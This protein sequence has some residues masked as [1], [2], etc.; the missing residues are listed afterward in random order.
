MEKIHCLPKSYI[1][2][3]AHRLFT[4]YWVL[5]NCEWP[6][7][8]GL[9]CSQD[10]DHVHPD[11]STTL[12]LRVRKNMPFA[13]K[14]ISYPRRRPKRLLGLQINA[15][16]TWG[17]GQVSKCWKKEEKEKENCK[18]KM[19]VHD[20]YAWRKLFIV[21]FKERSRIRL[22]TKYFHT[23]AH[24]DLRVWHSPPWIP[25]LTRQYV[26]GKYVISLKY[27]QLH[28]S[29]HRSRMFWHQSYMPQRGSTNTTYNEQSECT[30]EGE[31]KL[32]FLFKIYTNL[33]VTGLKDERGSVSCC[34]V[35]QL[36][37]VLW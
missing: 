22:A 15:S 29:F 31:G 12:T 5:S 28:I 26:H 21:S 33:Q 34:S 16:K 27:L 11:I 35:F 7:L 30:I 19:I 20:L 2:K 1:W 14:S 9:S 10:Q 23:H 6:L 24:L 32:C 25:A 36:P 37:K 17:Y 8:R 13:Q 18:I 4:L 3:L